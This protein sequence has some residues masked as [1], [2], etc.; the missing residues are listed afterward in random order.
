MVLV[1]APAS[2]GAGIDWRKL[3]DVPC[4][5]QQV[6]GSE[7]VLGSLMLD[8][9]NDFDVY[10][11][12]TGNRAL[13]EARARTLSNGCIRVERIFP[14]ASLVYSGGRSDDDGGIAAAVASGETERLALSATLP[15][16]ILY[17]TVI[18]QADGSIGFRPDVYGRDRALI[19]IGGASGS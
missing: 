6:P 17:W 2:D 11:H 19:A 18:P 13:F 1:D 9:P 8:M 12:D 4:R 10:L 5:V 7:N 3:R 14:L 15:V 16:Y